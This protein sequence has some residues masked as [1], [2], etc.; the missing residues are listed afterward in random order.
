ME[1]REVFLFLSLVLV[2]SFLSVPLLVYTDL[3]LICCMLFLTISFLNISCSRIFNEMTHILLFYLCRHIFTRLEWTVWKQN[4]HRCSISR[5]KVIVLFCNNNRSVDCV[6]MY[7]SVMW[8]T[9]GKPSKE[10][11]NVRGVS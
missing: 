7:M 4:R 3:S 10:C 6:G 5:E 1:S 2:P 9:D 8:G 11:C